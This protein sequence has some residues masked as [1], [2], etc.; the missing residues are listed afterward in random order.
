M[1]PTRGSKYSR[2]ASLRRAPRSLLAAAACD[3]QHGACDG[4]TLT[5]AMGGAKVTFLAVLFV[6]GVAT[7][8]LNVVPP[9]PPCA[10]DA[11]S[12]SHSA[13]LTCVRRAAL[14]R[15]VRLVLRM[16]SGAAGRVAFA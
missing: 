6:D 15:S 1:R 7:A 10:G 5:C 14:H 11:P 8:L 16:A 9:V 3:M 4:R 13:C 2:L 12:P